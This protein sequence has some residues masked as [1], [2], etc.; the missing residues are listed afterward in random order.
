MVN[1]SQALFWIFLRG[2]YCVG[3]V[4]EGSPSHSSARMPRSPTGHSLRLFAQSYDNIE[5]VAMCISQ[6]YRHPH[7]RQRQHYMARVEL[8]GL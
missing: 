7:H 6:V 2:R 3:A 4:V 8:R 1:M 5:V